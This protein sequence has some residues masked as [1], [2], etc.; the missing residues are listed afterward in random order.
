MSDVH[1]SD[2]TRIGY[3]TQGT[4]PAIILIDGAMCHRG[5]GPMRALAPGLAPTRTVVLYD[6]RGRGG[7]SDTLPYAVDREIEDIA[8]LISAVGAPAALLG[9]SSGGALAAL[10]AARLGGKVSDLI[11][12]EVPFMP[13]PARPAAFAYTAELGSALSAG[14][15]DGAVTA[16]L[17]RVGVPGNAVEHMKSL[18]AWEG[19]TAIAPTLGYD[20]AVMGDSSVP[21][22]LASITARTLSLAGGDSPDFLQ[23]GA[24]GIAELVPGAEFDLLDGQG[25]DVDPARLAE[26]IS[27][28]LGR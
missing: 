27:D 23:W 8:A 21:A 2:G 7:S 3:E 14:D 22:E 18:P 5:A 17:T 13:E 16:F 20:D 25:H 11:V 12:Y 15:R 9:M 26:R 28:F 19:M 10:A 1:S 24:R 6:R 4:G